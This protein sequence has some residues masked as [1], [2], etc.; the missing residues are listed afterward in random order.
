[1]C[2]Y[3]H[4]CVREHVFVYASVCALLVI[5]IKAGTINQLIDYR[6]R[7]PKIFDYFEL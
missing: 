3:L 1:M 2:V 7:F 6:N 4:A 5:I